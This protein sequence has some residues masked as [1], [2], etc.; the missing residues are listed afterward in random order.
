LVPIAAH[1]A[2]KINR[3]HKIVLFCPHD[4]PEAPDFP[5]RQPL[6]VLFSMH[7]AWQIIELSQKKNSEV[8]VTEQL[9]H[10]RGW[11]A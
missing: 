10:F 3:Y 4:A 8:Y 9:F 7:Q 2:V 6:L 1:Q 11:A 5:F